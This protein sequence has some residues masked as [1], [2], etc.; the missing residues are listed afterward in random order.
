MRPFAILIS[1]LALSACD[2][3]D[4]EASQASGLNA[5]NANSAE[6]I[7]ALHPRQREA[8]LFRAIRDAG[9]PCQDVV[10]AE[11]IEETSGKPTWRA[12]C[13]DGSSHLIIV[14]ADGTAAV[15]SRNIP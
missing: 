14:N 10:R 3:L 13:E 7:A 11:Q 15:V 6:A 2:R 8:V 4:R 12:R 1:L 9:L 5:A